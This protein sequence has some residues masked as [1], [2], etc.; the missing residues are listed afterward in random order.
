MLSEKDLKAFDISHWTA[1][2]RSIIYQYNR[3]GTLVYGEIVG[4]HILPDQGFLAEVI[5]KSDKYGN[6]QAGRC[7]L[8]KSREAI[9]FQEYVFIKKPPEIDELEQMLNKDSEEKIKLK[10]ELRAEIRAA[11]IAELKGKMKD[12][13]LQQPEEPSE[14]GE[15]VSGVDSGVDQGGRDLRKTAVKG[16]R[17][18]SKPKGENPENN[19]LLTF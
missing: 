2:E 9:Q 14:T 18:R 5:C 8:A 11:V 12:G 1:S 4:L 6:F 7:R 10:D 13:D 3:E 19:E 17:L 15:V 16:A